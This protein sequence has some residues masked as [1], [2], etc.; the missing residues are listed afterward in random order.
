MFQGKSHWVCILL[1]QRF[2]RGEAAFV[3]SVGFGRVVDDRSAEGERTISPHVGSIHIQSL[4]AIFD[5]CGDVYLETA[6]LW[7]AADP[8]ADLSHRVSFHDMLAKR[9]IAPVKRSPL[10]VSLSP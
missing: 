7:L 3:H 5:I 9:H 2:F 8:T 1:F 4:P 10:P 6:A